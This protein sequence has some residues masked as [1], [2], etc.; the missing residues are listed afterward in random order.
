MGVCVYLMLSSF[1]ADCFLLLPFWYCQWIDWILV[2]NFRLWDFFQF[3][4]ARR[5]LLLLCFVKFIDNK[6]AP[7]LVPKIELCFAHFCSVLF[8]VHWFFDRNFYQVFDLNRLDPMLWLGPFDS[9]CFR[10]FDSENLKNPTFCMNDRRL[11]RKCVE[12][13]DA[14]QKLKV[15]QPNYLI[16]TV[17]HKKWE[18]QSLWIFIRIKCLNLISL[19]FRKIS[20]LSVCNS[21]LHCFKIELIRISLNV[22]QLYFVSFRSYCR[23][24]SI[25]IDVFCFYVKFITSSNLTIDDIICRTADR[26]H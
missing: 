23:L 4:C 8:C 2:L 26:R 11:G 16:L 21:L 3:L 17:P 18:A 24:Y 14:A 7:I 1:S 13:I 5:C 9:N 22:L 10:W 20:S 19:F 15:D 25:T 6:F 12:R